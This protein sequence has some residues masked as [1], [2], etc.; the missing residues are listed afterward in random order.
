M[1]SS[2]ES[3]TVS[4]EQQGHVVT[5]KNSL[6]QLRRLEKQYISNLRSCM[7]IED[8]PLIRNS[9]IRVQARII[10]EEDNI[11]EV[12]QHFK[13][14]TSN[15]N[16]SKKKIRIGNYTP[17]THECS[18]DDS[19]YDIDV[20]TDNRLTTD[21]IGKVVFTK[22]LQVN[23]D[24][25]NGMNTVDKNAMTKKL[26]SHT[27]IVFNTNNGNGKNELSCNESIDLL[28]VNSNDGKKNFTTSD[29]KYDESPYVESMDLLSYNQFS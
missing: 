13:C 25:V 15:E 27:N 6:M 22:E 29:E 1:A 16:I 11:D 3:R 18:N 10:K 19:T 28:S 14:G 17:A 8:K 2:Y 4:K 7:D 20:G 5:L 23:G 21:P 12:E 9:L 26:F 24:R